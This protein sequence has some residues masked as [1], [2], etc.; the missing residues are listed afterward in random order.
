[1]VRILRRF[2]VLIFTITCILASSAVWADNT[3][4]DVNYHVQIAQPRLRVTAQLNHVE[5]KTLFVA[6]VT[7][8]AGVDNLAARVSGFTAQTGRGNGLPVKNQGRGLYEVETKG[9]SVI[10]LRYIFDFRAA[11]HNHNLSILTSSYLH[12]AGED[13][14]F[15]VFRDRRS[16][17]NEENNL[18]KDFRLKLDGLPP[19]WRTLVTYPAAPDGS[20]LFNDYGVLLHAGNYDRIDFKTDSL[21]YTIAVDKECQFDSVPMIRDVSK[22]INYYCRIFKGAP[23]DREL[24]VINQSRLKH[25][26]LGGQTKK[27][28]IIMEL[29]GINRKNQQKHKVLIAHLIGH[30]TFHM[31]LPDAFN[32]NTDDWE[33][34]WEGFTEY[35]TYRSLFR[36]GIMN[37]AQFKEQLADRYYQYQKLKLKTKVSLTMAA[38]RKFDPNLEYNSLIYDKGMLVAYLFD[39]RLKE[40]GKDF[41]RF[42]ADLHRELALPQQPVANR[43][44]VAFMNDYI[45][46]DSFTKRYVQGTVLLPIAPWSEF[47]LSYFKQYLRLPPRPPFPWDFLILLFS[48]GLVGWVIFKITKRRIKAHKKL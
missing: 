6:F 7:N 36:L 5:T 32:H 41:D 44:I 25:Y 42:L 43:E 48:L 27:Q 34:F 15:R 33:W 40:S 26:Y 35:E 4:I 45:G 16:A 30:E 18:C 22:V 47:G 39:K 46:D 19:G 31:W 28:N 9:E 38:S 3:L 37:Q 12:I 10:H 11:E 8:H 20:I 17:Q 14:L 2:S 13:F 23:V 1:L 24:I 21:A 29:G